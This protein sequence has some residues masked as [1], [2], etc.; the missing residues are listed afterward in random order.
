MYFLGR[1]EPAA[2]LLADRDGGGILVNTPPF[3]TAL[4]DAIGAVAKL[5]FIFFPSHLGARDVEAWRTASGARTLAHAGEALSIPGPLDI[6]LEREHRFSRTIDFLPMSGRTPGSCALRC[7]NL[8]GIVFFGPI[9]EHGADGWPAL[10][11]HS[12]DHS[13]E[14]RLIGALGLRDLKFDYAFCD[15]FDPQ[16]SRFGPGAAS[17]ISERLELILA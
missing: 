13:Y 9:L 2:F 4:L 10:A 1:T 12:E 16:S 14:N 6:R 11:P 17:A 8:P 15:N 7:R 3:D 5:N